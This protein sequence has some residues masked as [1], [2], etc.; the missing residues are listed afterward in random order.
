VLPDNAAERQREE[1]VGAF[2]AAREFFSK[3]LR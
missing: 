2:A 1:R 3:H